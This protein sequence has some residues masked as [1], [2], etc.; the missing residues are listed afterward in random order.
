MTIRAKLIIAFSV[1][2]LLSA[3]M[4]AYAVSA[5]STVRDHVESL[6]Q[7]SMERV[8]LAKEMQQEMTEI[9]SMQKNAILLED[10]V[11]MR[12]QAKQMDERQAHLREIEARHREVARS[13]AAADMEVYA[14]AMENYLA[15]SK[16]VLHLTQLNSDARARQLLFGE[17]RSAHGA[18]EA[19]IETVR[20]L[21]ANDPAIDASRSTELIVRLKGELSSLRVMVNSTLLERTEAGKET[22]LTEAEDT[23]DRFRGFLDQLSST[24]SLALGTRGDEAIATLRIAFDDYWALLELITSISLEN[25]DAKAFALSFGE[26]ANAYTSARDAL[27]RVLEGDRLA[28]E[29]DRARAREDYQATR[30][31]LVAV[32]LCTL[33]FGAASAAVLSIGVNRGLTRAVAV[34]R[35]VADGDLDVSLDRGRRDEIGTLMNALGDMTANLRELTHAAEQLANGDLSVEMRRRSPRDALGRALETM[36]EKLRDIIAKASA[37]SAAVASG[38]AQMKETAEGLSQ[39]AAQQAAAAQEASAAMEEMSS[40]IRQSAENATQTEEIATESAAEA[41]ESGEAVDK[42]VRAM[43]MIADKINII[44]EIAR[45]TDLL[46]LNAAVEAARAGSH[47]KG[48]AVVAS[49]VRKLAERS[50]EAAAEILQ[51]SGDT[52]AI[53]GDAGRMLDALVPKIQRTADLVQE[54]S[55]ATREQDTGA[56]QINQAI[57]DLDQVI[58]RTAS[59]AESAAQ[60][61]DHLS[62]QAVDLSG[63]IEYFR[64]SGN[65]SSKSCDAGKNGQEAIPGPGERSSRAPIRAKFDDAAPLPRQS[66]SINAASPTG[67]PANGSGYHL[68]IDSGAL[69]DAEFE[70]Y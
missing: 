67:S 46:A 6:V 45:Q 44:Q 3:G 28:L 4:A 68:D 1:V 51:L 37:S 62:N 14:G 26:A 22:Y 70:R 9:A 16:Q 49:E 32:A 38:S 66:A 12:E 27:D 29:A 5:L 30:F 15:L 8:R 36:I 50:Q 64:I 23:V 25:G 31:T 19:A 7:V 58:Q 55:A 63:L 10:P 48:F 13:E 11:L 20:T 56:Q 52:V 41:K 42:A 65:Y 57:R 33:V 21:L 2:I 60:T 17:A 24:V 61:S 54:I 40:T 53:S 59:A 34:A 35:A 18:V 39:G 47:G 69:G 43:K